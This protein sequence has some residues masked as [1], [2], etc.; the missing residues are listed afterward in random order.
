MA[1]ETVNLSTIN[2]DNLPQRKSVYA[3]FAQ[4]KESSKPINC[5][6]VGETDNLEERTKAHLAES[7]QNECLKKFM[8]SDKTKLMIYE[9]L[10][11]SDKTERL[12]K[13][14]DWITDYSPECN[15]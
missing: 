4:S 2:L 8:Q 6:Y 11:N 5:R 7:E 12:Q 14:K 1:K 15:K 9:L 3:I 10:P 13:E